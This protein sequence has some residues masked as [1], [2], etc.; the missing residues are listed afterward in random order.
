M[1]FT[2]LSREERRYFTEVMRN[3]EELEY[4]AIRYMLRQCLTKNGY[5]GG[6]RKRRLQW[7]MGNY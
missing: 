5:K 7:L 2:N 6:E 3:T 1:D 4:P